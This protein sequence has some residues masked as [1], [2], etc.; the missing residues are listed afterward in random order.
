MSNMKVMSLRLPADLADDLEI[1]ASVDETTISEVVRDAIG[2][3]VEKRRQEPG[4]RR[5]LEDRIAREKSL[6]SRGTAGPSQQEGED[7]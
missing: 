5:A 3:Y 6:L 2:R 4:F 7:R 1:V